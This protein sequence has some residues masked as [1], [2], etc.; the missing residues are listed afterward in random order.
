MCSILKISKIITLIFTLTLL[1]LALKIW[2]NEYY[3]T[4][5]DIAHHYGLA[6]TIAAKGLKLNNPLNAYLGGMELYPPATHVL[7]V[8]MGWWVKST[9][10]GMFLVSL[11]SVFGIYLFICWM[12]GFK[13]FIP[14]LI[15]SSLFLILLGCFH[16]TNAFVGGEIID[17]FFFAQVVGLFMVVVSIYLIGIL[18]ASFMVRGIISILITFAL[19]WVFPISAIEFAAAALIFQFLSAFQQRAALKKLSWL[20][21]SRW[22]VFVTLLGAA[23]I[24][25]P[26]FAFMKIVASSEGGI[27]L[28]IPPDLSVIL[29]TSTL[30]ILVGIMLRLFMRSS[31]GLLIPSIFIAAA[32]GICAASI[33]QLLVFYIADIGS[34]YGTEKHIFAIATFLAAVISVLAAYPFRE[35]IITRLRRGCMILASITA[36]LAFTIVLPKSGTPIKPLANYQQSIARLSDRRFIIEDHTVSANHR[37]NALENFIVSTG[38]LHYNIAV[39]I[40]FNLDPAYLGGAYPELLANHPIQYELV[41]EDTNPPQQCIRQQLS[42]KSLV[43]D[44]IC[45]KATHTP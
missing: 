31:S 19:G 27:N 3:A 41:S 17:N 8:M 13:E 24:L 43:V 1:F 16:W 15:S 2:G 35:I 28:R 45:M 33:A 20:V 42:D 38:D 11:I 23:I 29:L 12:M 44:Y 30:A 32:G 21:V 18:P 25:H 10:L 34:R 40:G 5:V 22:I 37:L 7:A 39:A 6:Q 14:T 26:T 9:I 36:F 4:S